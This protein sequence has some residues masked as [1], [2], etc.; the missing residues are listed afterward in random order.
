MPMGIRPLLGIKEGAVLPRAMATTTNGCGGRRLLCCAVALVPA[1]A[2]L[3]MTPDGVEKEDK[4]KVCS[5]AVSISPFCRKPPL[6]M[7]VTLEGAEESKKCYLG[8]FT[9]GLLCRRNSTNVAC[10]EI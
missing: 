4:R 10:N 7:I 5:L 8:C 2:S 1:G 9:E 6:L 3:A